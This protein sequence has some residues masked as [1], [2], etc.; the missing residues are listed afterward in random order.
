MISWRVLLTGAAIATF[1]TSL[2]AEA[3]SVGRP[4]RIGWLDSG[5]ISA[6][7]ETPFVTALKQMGHAEGRD[8]LVAARHA[9]GQFD[10][11]PA[12]AADLVSRKVDLIAA[13]GDPAIRAAKQETDTIP[14]VMVS[15]ADPVGLGFVAS[16]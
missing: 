1:A 3:R 11:L 5:G 9:E 2:A 8:F 12:L 10:Q 13:Y 15:S 6:A 16:L 4:W 14:I 7:R